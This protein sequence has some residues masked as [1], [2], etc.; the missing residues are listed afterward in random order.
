MKMNTILK[1]LIRFP[2][3]EPPLSGM[4][5]MNY[6]INNY[7]FN[8]SYFGG[9]LQ[10]L[11]AYAADGCLFNYFGA[12]STTPINQTNELIEYILSRNEIITAHFTPI[13]YGCTDPNASNY[14]EIQM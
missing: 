6:P 11:E 9:V 1:D 8:G 5:D 10:Q 7:P 2:N 13:I 12:N 4:V 14:N 3:I